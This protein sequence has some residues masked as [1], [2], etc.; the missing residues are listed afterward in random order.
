MTNGI[1][2]K[3]IIEAIKEVVTDVNF[4]VTHEGLHM[5]AMDSSHVALVSLILRSSEFAEYRCDRPQTLGIS[6][7]SLA[8]ILKL[9]G[10]D[11]AI[12]LK[13]EDEASVLTLIFEASESRMSEFSLNLLMFD[14]E[15]LGVPSQDY[16]AV[17]DFSSS[18]FARICRELLTITDTLE[19]TVSKDNITFSV[20]GDIGTGSVILR[21]NDSSKAEER[22]VIRAIESFKI[23]Y[24]LRYMNMFS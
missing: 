21:H 3:K 1:V 24:A 20:D 9:A 2:L 14:S 13:A 10:N 12:S 18:E 23:G 15:H 17:V 22:T 8:K 19:I 7:G 4:Q 5:Q 11:D 6:I 16:P